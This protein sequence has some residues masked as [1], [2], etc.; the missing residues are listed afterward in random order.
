MPKEETDAEGLEHVTLT[1]ADGKQIKLAWFSALE[2]LASIPEPELYEDLFAALRGEELND[3]AVAQ[4][5]ALLSEHADVLDLGT[6]QV[7]Q[8]LNEG[9]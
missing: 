7:L 9:S 4:A 2:D 6:I 5:G 3:D 8:E 1:M